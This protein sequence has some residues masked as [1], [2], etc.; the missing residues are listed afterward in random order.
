MLLAFVTILFSCNVVI[1][2]PAKEERGRELLQ[3]LA[4][5]KFEEFAAAGDETM[6][7]GFTAAA[8]QN[9]WAKLEF[10]LGAY[11]AIVDVRVVPAPPYD[12][13]NLT[14]R[15]QRGKAVIRIVLDDDDHIA[16]LWLDEVKPQDDPAAPL[17]PYVDKGAFQERECV[18]TAESAEVEL[19]GTLSIPVGGSKCPGVVLVH[20]SGPHDRDETVGANRPFRDLAWGLASR[21]IVVVRYEKRTRAFPNFKPASEWTLEMETIDDA[22]GAVGLLRGTDEVDGD[23]IFII[24]HS[25]GAIAAPLIAERDPHLAGIVLMA[26]TPRSILDLVN[27]QVAYISKADGVVS[28][29]EKQRMAA[30]ERITAAIRA[31]KLDEVPADS[32]LPAEYMAHMDRLDVMS[33][34]RGLKLPMLILQGGRDYQVTKKDFALWK[35]GLEGHANV[36]FELFDDL[37]HLFISGTGPSVPAEY[38]QPGHVAPAVIERLATW[39]KAQPSLSPGK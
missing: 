10:Q 30:V 36:S 9:L 4:D 25:L 8:C 38:A 21:G 12:A 31:G 3:L 34:A 26:G 7:A 5:G 6:R 37:N 27:E 22:I 29:D 14:C 35:T 24:G 20:G 16:G 13:V 17:P 19:P 18:V 28:D 11:E 39:I 33:A 2:T 32:G 23:R 1:D 15:F